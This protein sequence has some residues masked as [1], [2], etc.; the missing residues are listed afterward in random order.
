MTTIN[1]PSGKRPVSLAERI[2]YHDNLR[3]WFNRTL[4]ARPLEGKSVYLFEPAFPDV[5]RKEAA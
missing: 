3:K 4:K 1:N 2:I 5:Q